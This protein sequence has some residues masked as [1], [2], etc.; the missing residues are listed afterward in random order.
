MLVV[1][2]EGYSI[3]T[4]GQ[5]Y[6]V[7]DRAKSLVYQG[8]DEEARNYVEEKLAVEAIKCIESKPRVIGSCLAAQSPRLQDKFFESWVKALSQYI[9]CVKITGDNR[10]WIATIRALMEPSK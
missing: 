8:S 2:V 3:T 5:C 6:C 10:K 4:D 7:H 1:N 9:Q